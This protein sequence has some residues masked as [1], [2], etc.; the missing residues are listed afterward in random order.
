MDFFYIDADGNLLTPIAMK[1][2]E[3]IVM[4]SGKMETKKAQ[5]FPLQKNSYFCCSKQENKLHEGIRIPGTRRSIY[6]YGQRLI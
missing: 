6:R 1:I 5:A 3:E 2:L 4:K